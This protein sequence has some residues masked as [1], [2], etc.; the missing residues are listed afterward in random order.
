MYSALRRISFLPSRSYLQYLFGRVHI[1]HNILGEAINRSLSYNAQ[2]MHIMY[3][4][5]NWMKVFYGPK[6]GSHWLNNL[7]FVHVCVSALKD[8]KF[9]ESNG[10]RFGY[11]ALHVC[12][13]EYECYSDC[14]IWNL[15]WIS[16]FMLTRFFRVHFNIIFQYC[17]LKMRFIMF[18]AY[19][20]WKVRVSNHTKE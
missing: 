14:R 17:H 8:F 4:R 19:L 6:V 1:S 3:A 11:F 5:R 13:K 20:I 16:N 10:C 2:C 18:S 9:F 12:A 15:L 7:Y